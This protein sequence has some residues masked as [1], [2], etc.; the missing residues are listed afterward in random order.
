MQGSELDSQTPVFVSAEAVAQSIDLDEVL[1]TLRRTYMAQPAGWRSAGRVVVRGSSGARIR[2]LAAVLP[3]GDMLGAK[4]H[5]QP[6]DGNSAFLIA[7]FSQSDGRLLG[8]MDGRAITQLR[9]GA[10]SA[11]ALDALAAPGSLDLAVL[12]SGA[13]ARAHLRAVAALRPLN[14]VRVFSTTPE[15]RERFAADLSAELSVTI[16]SCD[17]AEDAVMS[18]NT[19]IAA[20][21]SHGERPIFDPAALKDGTVIVSVGSTVPEQRELDERVLERAALIIADEPAELLQQSGD[22]IAAARADI[23]LAGKTHSLAELIQGTIPAPIDHGAINVFKSVGSALQD[24]AVAGSVLQR[25]SAR[26]R[27]IPLGIT[28]TPK[29]HHPTPK[30]RLE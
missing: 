4:L 11:L 2:A 29:E 8:L 21:R 20:A 9:T 30:E 10:T 3:T 6:A 25:A 16:R 7:I 12:G 26:G 27:T 5:A 24:V 28:L 13:E 18:A 1:A 15:R 19:V 22:C 23:K 17:S 14:S